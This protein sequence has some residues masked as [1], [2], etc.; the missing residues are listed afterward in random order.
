MG[1]SSATRRA[2]NL[3]IDHDLLQEARSLGVNLSRAADAGI[4]L[5][6][7]TA[8]ADQWKRE[9]MSALKSSNSYV[10]EQGLPLADHR[11]F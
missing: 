3:S 7:A 10:E 8:R 4:A 1:K 2:A 6:T 11:Q 9:N 5:A